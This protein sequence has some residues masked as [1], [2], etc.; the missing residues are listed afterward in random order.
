M[1]PPSSSAS[2]SDDGIFVVTGATGGLG[3]RV[4]SRLLA[5]G[6]HVR[7]V[8]RVPAKASELLGL[9]P[10]AAGLLLEFPYP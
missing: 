7:A 4:V 8:A 9:L 1:A 6:K 10:V 5:Q 3:R 2:S